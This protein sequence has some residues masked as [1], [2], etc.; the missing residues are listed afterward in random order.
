MH[1]LQMNGQENEHEDEE[2]DVF[3]HRVKCDMDLKNVE[4]LSLV[5]IEV[6]L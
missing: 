1:K 6:L 4:T 5:D 2:I 3:I